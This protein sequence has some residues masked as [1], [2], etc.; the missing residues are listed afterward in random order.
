M[1]MQSFGGRRV[2]R[3]GNIVTV[4]I[5]RLGWRGPF[6]P[7]PGRA[8]PHQERWPGGAAGWRGRVLFTQDQ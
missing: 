3:V 1:F 6:G 4:G 5:I 7:V 2:E 8:T